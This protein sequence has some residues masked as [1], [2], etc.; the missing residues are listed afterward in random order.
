MKHV[1]ITCKNYTQQTTDLQQKSAFSE[2]VVCNI[3]IYMSSVSYG[4]ANK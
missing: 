1:N 4:H 3:H 2:N